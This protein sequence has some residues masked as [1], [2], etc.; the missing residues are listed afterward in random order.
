VDRVITSLN[1]YQYSAS[2][3]QTINPLAILVLAPLFALMWPR[4][5]KKG[6]EPSIPTKMGIGLI[7]LSLGFIALL[8]AAHILDAGSQN[9]SPLW[10]I[11]AYIIFTMGELCLS[12]IGLSMVSKLSPVRFVCCLMATW[13]LASSIAGI[14][15]GYLGSLCPSP[16]RSVTT[17]LGKYQLMDLHHFL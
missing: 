8:P 11:L 3:F 2:W 6:H 7:I 1:N 5:R 17:L 16:T 12:P 15:S 9:I 10:L 4:F 13:F 14:A